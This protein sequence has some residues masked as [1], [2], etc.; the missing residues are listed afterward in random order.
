MAP[1]AARSVRRRYGRTRAVPSPGVDPNGPETMVF[2]D[3]SADAP[4]LL[5][6]SRELRPLLSLTTAADRAPARVCQFSHFNQVSLFNPWIGDG[7]PAPASA[8]GQEIVP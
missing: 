2:P 3:E 1:D 6:L 7:S 5:L 8:G 4:Y